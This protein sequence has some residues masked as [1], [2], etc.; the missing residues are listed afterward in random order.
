MHNYY[1]FIY[2]KVVFEAVEKHLGRGN[3]VLFARSATAGTQRFPL[4]WG[5]DC[6]ST[7]E[8]MHESLR[9]GLSLALSGFAYWSVDIGGFEG[10]PGPEIYKRWVAWGLM[11]SHSRLHGSKCYHVLNLKKYN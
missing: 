2:N 1:T 3:A 10:N 5:G 8:A 7:F 11:L 6:E 4:Q 9:G